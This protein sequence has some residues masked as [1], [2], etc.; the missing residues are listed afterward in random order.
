MVVFTQICHVRRIPIPLIIMS[1]LLVS[2][3]GEEKDY[4]HLSKLTRSKIVVIVVD[5]Y[6][7]MKSTSV[8]PR[9]INSNSS[10]TSH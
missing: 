8:W 9:H 7:L 4:Q 6:R 1:E 2:I 10:P 3:R 5:L